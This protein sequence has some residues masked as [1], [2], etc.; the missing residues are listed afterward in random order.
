MLIYG[1]G[2]HKPVPRYFNCFN[3]LLSSNISLYKPK[4]PFLLN[5]QSNSAAL[6]QKM[7][8]YIFLYFIYF[9]IL[10]IVGKACCRSHYEKKTETLLVVLVKGSHLYTD[11][12]AVEA[13]PWHGYRGSIVCS[14]T[15][16][17]AH[18]DINNLFHFL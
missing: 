18:C 13:V 12:S 1:G 15:N 9:L 10:W 6:W 16:E 17:N 4:I 8:A 11:I 3:A 5:Y 14:T 7:E 2:T